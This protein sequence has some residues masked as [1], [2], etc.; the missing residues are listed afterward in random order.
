[1]TPEFGG[2]PER[3]TVYPEA[4]P[5][6][7]APRLIKP[8]VPLEARA[9]VSELEAIPGWGE[10]PDGVGI[11]LSGGGIRS[12]SF[13]LGALQSFERHGML[14]GQTGAKYLSAVSGGSYIATALTMVT[15]GPIAG[16]A[17]EAA[18]APTRTSNAFGPDLR[19]FAHGSPEEQYLRHRTL[20]LTHGRAGVPGVVWR[21]LLGVLFNVSVVTLALASLS[22]P[23]G[24]LLAKLWPALQEGCPSR[25]PTGPNF[26]IP[27]GLWVAVVVTAGLA[28]LS[29]FVWLCWRFRSAWQRTL[30]G[31]ASGVLLAGALLTALFFI[32]IPAL[33]HVARPDYVVSTVPQSAHA[34]KVT[35]VTAAS[36]GLLGLVTAWIAAARRLIAKPS[37][38]ESGVLNSL[39]GWAL[40]HRSFLV[41]VAATIAGP[42]LVLVGIVILAYWGAAYLPSR[43][44]PGRW[45]LVSWIG[46]VIVLVVLWFRADV[47]AW[48]LYPLYRNRLS[49]GFVLQRTPRVG[50]E[51]SPTAVGDQDASER[52]YETPYRL[53]ECQPDDFPEVIICA[54]ANISDYGATPSGS[55]VTSFTFSSKQIGGPLVG[56]Q[57]TDVYE[58]ALG[59]KAQSRFTT[60]PTAMAISGAAFSPS[61]GKMTHAPFRFF[62]AL[63]NLRLGVW[64][65]NPRQLDLFRERS[66][67]HQVLPRSQYFLREMV[68]KN[69]LDAP[70]LYVTDGGHYENLG[71]VELL[72]RKC[73]MI[74]CIDASGDQVDTFDTLGGALQTAEG[75][76]QISI[77]IDP[78]GDMAPTTSRPASGPWFVKAPFCK[79]TITYPDNQTATLIVIKAGI[80]TDAPWSVVS[81]ADQNSSFPCD[82]TLDQLYDADRFDAYREL[83][84]FCADKAITTITGSVV[85]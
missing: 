75:E 13:C 60:L 80:P 85:T 26:A 40:K 24:W 9:A 7:K 44:G 71:L 11:C 5:S 35:T 2:G 42:L 10:A 56:A 53:S 41:N 16:S 29:G 12:A 37:S 66:V 8:R 32:G 50:D 48:S 21:V 25:C 27:L 18:I 65:P 67:V 69:N 51:P 73:K 14:Y 39:K 19:P 36:V 4:K 33:V 45:E 49:A 6:R 30:F 64:V 70:F 3:K 15:K 23:Y 57:P 1:M 83:G 77:D 58:E 62:M 84:E 79:G 63:A 61:M 81:F 20:Y 78:E 54:A 59:D 76:L 38:V 47:T 72:R 34:A 17:D 28:V 55:H 82:P 31:G 46:T 74:W 43:S 52:P 68:G 22:V